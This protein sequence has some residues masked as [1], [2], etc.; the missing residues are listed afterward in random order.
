MEKRGKRETAI[1]FWYIFLSVPHPPS[2]LHNFGWIN[3]LP[4]TNTNFEIT[5]RRVYSC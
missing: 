2:L 4:F 3:P 5:W 1:V